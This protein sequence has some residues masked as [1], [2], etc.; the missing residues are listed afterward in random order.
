MRFE[1][2][3]VDNA[4]DD[5]SAA[6]AEAAAP[7][8]WS[9]RTVV[10]NDTN[11]GFG[12]ANNDGLRRARGRWILFLNPDTV[13]PAG[14]LVDLLREASA[15]PR[16]GAVS[17]SLV[18]DDGELQP[19]VERDL[20]LGR[21]LAGFLRVGGRNRPQ[22]APAS[23]P[24]LAVDWVHAAALAAP[25]GAGPGP[26]RV[27]RTVLPLWGGS[28]SVRAGAAHGAGGRGGAGGALHPRRRRCPRRGSGGEEVA[29]VRRVA[30]LGRYLL[31]HQGQFAIVTYSLVATA[32]YV[33]AALGDVARA[34][35]P[36]APRDG[37]GRRDPALGRHAA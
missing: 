31:L 21:V 32:A 11:K 8:S 14:G 4:S 1:V 9:G 24:P 30:V 5:G 7:R 19:I 2:I 3:V 18:G 12:A 25:D 23:G 10:R 34:I 36:G 28:R 35:T 20:R 37:A 33:L 6:A 22:P 16:A 17:P 15:L 27:R 13:V 29:A 26:W